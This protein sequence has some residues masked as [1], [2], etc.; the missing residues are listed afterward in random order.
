MNFK[1]YTYL[2][3]KKTVITDK[4]TGEITTYRHV[5]VVVPI[6]NPTGNNDIIGFEGVSCLV[7]SETFE[8]FKKQKLLTVFEGAVANKG[9]HKGDI[10]LYDFGKEK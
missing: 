3:C 8:D 1:K 7:D 9:Q 5:N 6:N 2:G 4:Q 10:L